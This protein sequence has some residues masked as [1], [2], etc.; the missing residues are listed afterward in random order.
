MG[1]AAGFPGCTSLSYW[2]ARLAVSPSARSQ[3]ADRFHPTTGWLCCDPQ[4]LAPSAAIAFRFIA[5]SPALPGR[6]TRPAGLQPF[7]RSSDVWAALRSL[8]TDTHSPMFDTALRASPMRC[9]LCPRLHD[10]PGAASPASPAPASSLDADDRRPY[11]CPMS[12]IGRA[13]PRRPR[14]FAAVARPCHRGASP[15]PRLHSGPLRLA[16]A[17]A[18]STRRHHRRASMSGIAN[19]LRTPSAT[20]I[21]HRCCAPSSPACAPTTSRRIPATFVQ[22]T[23]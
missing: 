1:P 7:P 23:R 20:S 17:A 19:R 16:S 4:R 15:R 12:G 10:R 13:H 21:S 8:G 9:T 11:R 3:R 14:S 22:H 18:P 5:A 6:Y 2:A